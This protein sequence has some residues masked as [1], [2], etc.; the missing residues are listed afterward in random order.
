MGGSKGAKSTSRR[1]KRRAKSSRKS[2]KK[3]KKKVHVVDGNVGLTEAQRINRQC[4]ELAYEELKRRVSSNKQIEQTERHVDEEL[5]FIEDK[6]R[7]FKQ[8]RRQQ[9]LEKEKSRKQVQ[10][11]REHI[12]NLRKQLEKDRDEDRKKLEKISREKKK[13]LKTSNLVGSR[14][15]KLSS[16]YDMS[17]LQPHLQKLAEVLQKY[18]N[19]ARIALFAKPVDVFRYPGY[20]QVIRK[21]IS[22][23]KVRENLFS[24]IYKNETDFSEDMMLIWINAQVFNPPHNQVYLWAAEFQHMFERDCLHNGWKIPNQAELKKQTTRPKPQPKPETQRTLTTHE[25]N[26]IENYF[27]QLPE[28]EMD[29]I[30]EMLPVG[31]NDEEEVSIDIQ[32]LPTVLQWKILNIIRDHFKFD[33]KMLKGETIRSFGGI[34]SGVLSPVKQPASSVFKS[35]QTVPNQRRDSRKGGAKE[36]IPE[37][38][39]R[40]GGAKE[41]I[42]EQTFR[43]GGAKEI[44]PEQTFRKGGA[45]EIM[46]EIIPEQTKPL[47]D[48]YENDFEFSSIPENSVFNLPKIP[49][50]KKQKIPKIQP[51]SPSPEPEVGELEESD[52]E[53]SGEVNALSTAFFQD[54]STAQT[55]KAFS[56]PLTPTPSNIPANKWDVKVDG[57]IAN[58]IEHQE[59]WKKFDKKPEPVVEAPPSLPEVSE[60]PE[61]QEMEMEEEIV[62]I[63]EPEPPERKLPVLPQPIRPPDM[64][65]PEVNQYEQA[66]LMKELDDLFD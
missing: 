58:K 50:P 63:S 9:K 18:Y 42:P 45:K 20:K 56:E 51:L 30:I 2:K 53:D 21:P 66:D 8:K 12:F 65:M 10:K 54:D 13:L 16:K 44:I 57:E 7:A 52:S 17:R 59:F 14:H 55:E 38:T 64:I 5:T 3:R 24:G 26:L 4:L 61:A 40:K 15:Q 23:D 36:I 1:T 60:L 19:Q 25:L 37:Q 62:K 22:L 34:A 35:A 6:F 49:T 46:A 43:K 47:K 41:I 27:L 33:D 32:S 48:L 31:E 39:F 28:E 11:T 29:V